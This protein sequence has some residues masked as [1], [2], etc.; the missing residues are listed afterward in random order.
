METLAAYGANHRQYFLLSE[1]M[2]R[3]TDRDA[4]VPDVS[5]VDVHYPGSRSRRLH[6]ADIL[7]EPELLPGFALLLN[8]IFTLHREY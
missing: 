6:D 8:E 1:S 5:L 4:C 7:A 2:F 3:V